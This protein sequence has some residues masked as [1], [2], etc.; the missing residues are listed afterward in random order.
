MATNTS[1]DAKPPMTLS[2]V[3]D[4]IA[5]TGNGLWYVRVIF[6]MAFNQVMLAVEVNMLTFVVYCAE[7]TWDLGDT[8]G[9]VLIDCVY[10]GLFLGTMLWGPIADVIGRLY[11]LWI[12]MA[13]TLLFN[14]LSAVAPTFAIFV[15]L[16]VL[17]G[18]F[19]GAWIVALTYVI[20]I[21][22][23]ED[24]GSQTNYI[25]CAWGVGTV[26][27]SVMA[28]LIIPT[29]GWRAY[30][31]IGTL[32]FVL[33]LPVLYT[34]C[35]SPRWLADQGRHKEA[36]EALEY[37]AAANGTVVPCSS[38]ITEFSEET[39]LQ[40]PVSLSIWGVLKKSVVNYRG[41]F[42]PGN[43]TNTI[44][45]TSATVL[46]SMSYTAVLLYDNDVLLGSDNS[47]SFNYKEITILATSEVVGIALVTPLLDRADIPLVGGRRGTIRLGVFAGIVPMVLS[48]Y[49][50]TGQYVWAYIARSGIL[51]AYNIIYVLLPEMYSTSHRVTA[52][53]F[54]TLVSYGGCALACWLIY[55]DLAN[56]VMMWVTA[57]VTLVLGFMTCFFPE[58]AQVELS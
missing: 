39:G 12:T 10:V 40:G 47:C 2:A 57:A 49:A 38:L 6:I 43:L 14:L 11:T 16:R 20:E 46:S 4:D 52:I 44:M 13:F 26:A 18:F 56:S 33:A 3:L 50:I 32:V 25:N 31:A 15:L 58:T 42:E 7:E 30:I 19:E 51:V 23:V 34:L 27:V 29:Y 21:L 28:W 17:A 8:A 22:P 1:S 37:M 45:M 35:E 48:G 53:A 41:L 5:A 9:D 36:L 55:S 54:A 24:R